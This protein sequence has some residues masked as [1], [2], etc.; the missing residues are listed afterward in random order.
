MGLLKNGAKN[1]NYGALKI[2]SGIEIPKP[3]TGPRSPRSEIF[4]I[5]K[6][7]KVGDSIVV[8]T[9]HQYQYVR[10]VALSMDVK[11]LMREQEDGTIRV[12]KVKK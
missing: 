3:R 5:I 10:K 4:G 2:E 9:K 8:N 7:M 6:A 11:V 1:F 12:W